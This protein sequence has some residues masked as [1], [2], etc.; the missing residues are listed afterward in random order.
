MARLV[1][2]YK[3][4]KDLTA[5]DRYYF[6]T[7]IPLAKTIPGLRKYEISD[8]GVDSPGGPS[9]YHLVA[10]LH[11]DSVADIQAAFASPEGQATAADLGKFAD[12]GVELLL[13]ETRE[14]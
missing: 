1:A 4:P 6:S 3:T 2:L 9:G 5:F 12:G 14:V 11:F 7:H 13:F 8:G 10:T